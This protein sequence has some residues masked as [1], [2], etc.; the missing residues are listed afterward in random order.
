MRVRFSELERNSLNAVNVPL[1]SRR[2]QQPEYFLD[3]LLLAAQVLGASVIKPPLGFDS[4]PEEEVCK[5]G[6]TYYLLINL[7]IV[8]IPTL[9]QLA[10]Y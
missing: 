4:V 5:L 6:I 1:A 2:A 3:A 8:Q 9:L 10:S 7:C